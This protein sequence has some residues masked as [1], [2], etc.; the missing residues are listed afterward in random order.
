MACHLMLGTCGMLFGNRDER[1][2]PSW[3]AAAGR[4]S[5]PSFLRLMEQNDA[6]CLQAGE[7]RAEPQSRDRFAVLAFRLIAILLCAGFW[8]AAISLVI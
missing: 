2:S 7:M 3:R 5:H 1:H 6:S 8:T 4:L